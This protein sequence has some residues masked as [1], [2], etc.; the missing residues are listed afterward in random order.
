MNNIAI[1]LLP[2]GLITAGGILI[3][4]DA[5]DSGADD[6]IG[7]V[8][9]ALA[10]IIPDVL[11]TTKSN[12]NATLKAMRDIETVAHAYRVQVNDPTLNT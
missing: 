10:P 12:A 1:A 4:K 7:Q 9:I 11:S 3:G 8:C 2:I 6:A 5:N